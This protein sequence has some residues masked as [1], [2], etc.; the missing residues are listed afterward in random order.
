[1]KKRVWI[2]VESCNEEYEPNE[3]VGAIFGEV[4][5]PDTEAD[6]RG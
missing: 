5:K 3:G 6:S 2:C 4:A 1:M